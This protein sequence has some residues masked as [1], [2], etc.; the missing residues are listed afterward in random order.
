MPY[1]SIDDDDLFLFARGSGAAPTAY[2]PMTYVPA[3]VP[4]GGY[5]VSELALINQIQQFVMAGMSGGTAAGTGAASIT[6]LVHVNDGRSLWLI[7]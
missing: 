6:V 2:T 1:T 7:S 4:L 5:G 3:A